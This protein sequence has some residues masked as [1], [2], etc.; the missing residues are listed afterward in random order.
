MPPRVSPNRGGPRRGPSSRGGHPGGGSRGSRLGGPS[1]TAEATPPASPSTAT[2]TFIDTIE[3]PTPHIPAPTGSNH[4]T[5]FR[6]QP[7]SNRGRGAGRGDVPDRGQF[8]ARNRGRGRGRGDA[9]RGG[10]PGTPSGVE[11]T[12]ATSITTEIVSTASF[13]QDPHSAIRGQSFRGRG[14]RGSAR[15]TPGPFRGSA[16]RG[17]RGGVFGGGFVGSSDTTGS[18]SG[19]PGKSLFH[20]N[21]SGC[22]YLSSFINP[23]SN[24]VDDIETFGAKRPGYGTGGRVVKII[25]N[26]FPASIPSAIYYQY[27]GE[28]PF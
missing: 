23:R 28:I 14:Y 12:P 22:V 27:D 10:A 1:S 4:P 21:S 2:T 26:A 16:P 24:I 6:G 5:P 19:I 3:T 9:S 17:G 15:G 7:S 20:K 11:T 25:I 8:A 18:P 13:P